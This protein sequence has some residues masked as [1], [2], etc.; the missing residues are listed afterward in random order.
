MYEKF[1]APLFF[2]KAGRRRQKANTSLKLTVSGQ[3]FEIRL[4]F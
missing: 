3:E 2:K 4:N 1:F